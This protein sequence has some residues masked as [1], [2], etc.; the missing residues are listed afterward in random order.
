MGRK[1]ANTRTVGDMLAN[2][3]II[4]TKRIYITGYSLVAIVDLYGAAVDERNAAVVYI[5]GF[6]PM[7][8]D[9]VNKETDRIKA[10]FH[11]HGLSPWLG[12]FLDNP[13]I[14]P[15][16]DNYASCQERAALQTRE[17]L[18]TVLGGFLRF[19]SFITQAK[20]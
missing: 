4:D 1:V 20:T 7:R 14:I 6:T 13:S 11:H 10:Y 9:T 8:L 3:D 18:N 19:I 2:L 12:F 15:V 16:G 17:A 5:C